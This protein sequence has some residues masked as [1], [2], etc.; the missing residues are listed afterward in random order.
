MGF[1]KAPKI[2]TTTAASNPPTYTPPPVVSETV[3]EDSTRSYDQQRSNKRGLLS[4]IL[5]T[6]SSGSSLAPQ[7]TGN[8]TLG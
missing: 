4:T 7:P 3:Q 8:T 2:N 6:R 1:A 5:S